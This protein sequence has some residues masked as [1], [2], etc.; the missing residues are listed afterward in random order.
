MVNGIVVVGV[1]LHQQ[2][3]TVEM[4]VRVSGHSDLQFLILSPLG[5]D[6]TIVHELSS[7]FQVWIHNDRH[8]LV[9]HDNVIVGLLQKLEVLN[10]YVFC[11]V[12]F[13]LFTL[14]LLMELLEGIKE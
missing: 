6:P 11:C 9:L 2:I 8:K 1:E 14:L 4:E 3:L 7:I 13:L 12:S 5:N 10:F